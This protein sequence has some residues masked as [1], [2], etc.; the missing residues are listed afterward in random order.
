M[1]TNP[2]SQFLEINV[3]PHAK[4]FTLIKTLISV[5]GT[6]VENILTSLQLIVEIVPARIIALVIMNMFN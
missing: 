1:V 3:L 5:H 2:I 4:K 6:V